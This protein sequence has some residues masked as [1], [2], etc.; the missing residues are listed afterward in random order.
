MKKTSYAAVL[1]MLP[2][3][4]MTHL[5]SADTLMDQPYATATRQ[6][7]V[8]VYGLPDAQGA[9]LQSSEQSMFLFSLDVGN[10][11]SSSIEGDRAI[12]LDGESYRANFVWRQGIAERWEVGFEV[13]YWLHD[14]GFL[15]GTVENFHDLFDLDNGNR[16]LFSR[17]SLRYRYLDMNTS[18]V[19]YSLDDDAEGIGDV[20]LNLAYQLSEGQQEQWTV[21]TSLKLPTGDAGKLTGSESMDLAVALHYSNPQWLDESLVL[22]ASGGVLW[23]EGTDV[24]AQEHNDIVWYGS[25]T[26]SWRWRDW[27]SWKVQL[28]AHTAFYDSPLKELGDPA[29]QLI[30]GGT[31][32]SSENT[33]FDFSIS[34][35]LIV[36]TAP[37]VVFQLALRTQL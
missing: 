19:I 17:D 15:D 6:P 32:R 31:F 25:S 8:Q 24:I 13:P 10:T 4:T 5:V 3:I 2:A 23:M 34:E 35:D 27:V 9:E 29:V 1:L 18:Q 28:D 20:R 37:D 12:F 33:S 16:E 21:R 30:L 14:G 26:V 36:N 22:H 11:F 7:L